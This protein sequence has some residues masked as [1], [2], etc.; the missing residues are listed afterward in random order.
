LEYKP[1]CPTVATPG[2]GVLKNKTKEKMLTKPVSSGNRFS[3][4]NGTT[5]IQSYLMQG[6]GNMHNN[7]DF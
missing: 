6:L 5:T 7:I 4:F 2:T 1:E 3:I